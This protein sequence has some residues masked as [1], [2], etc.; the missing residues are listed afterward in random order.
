MKEPA[1]NLKFRLDK[2]H[3][4]TTNLP[5]KICV[6]ILTVAPPARHLPFVI[7]AATS[8]NNAAEGCE[9]AATKTS[10]SPVAA[11]APQLRARAIWF[12]GSKTTV[13]PASRAICAV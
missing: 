6:S 12:T 5:E 9:P 10:Q 2:F 13:A 7:C 4:Q 1:N 8:E 3:I 11:A